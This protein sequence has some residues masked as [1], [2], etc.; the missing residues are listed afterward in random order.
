[1]TAIALPLIPLALA[2][3]AAP[4]RLPAGEA[5][6]EVIRG[7][8][9]AILSI[10]AG[11]E[12][13]DAAKEAE[14]FAII[15]GVTD[16]ETIA[17]AVTERFCRDLSA[18]QCREFR[19][20]FI[21]LLRV[22]SVKKL[23][24]YRADRFDYLGEE[25]GAE[26]AVVSTVAHYKDER[27]SLVYSLSRSGGGWRIVNYIVDDVDTVRNYRKQFKRLFAEKSFGEVIQR[28]RDRIAA[29]RQEASS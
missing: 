1:L 26:E 19:E 24:R 8:N 10:Y 14:I 2:A 20:V 4:V 29:Y 16:F 12:K 23:G 15:D 7:S 25:V 21:E 27:I 6:L 3:L 22:S 5:P 9:E 13:I 11:A 28:L 18:G 17:T